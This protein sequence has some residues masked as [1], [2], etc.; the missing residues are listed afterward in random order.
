M[1]PSGPNALAVLLSEPEQLD[2]VP[3]GKA[4]AAFKKIPLQ[5]AA[6]EAKKCWGIVSDNATPA[7]ADGL[8]QALTQ[9]GLR[10]F[11]APAS[12]L[13]GPR[14]PNVVKHINIEDQGLAVEAQP[15][16][17]RV[18]PWTY[19]S[20]IAVSL[21][22]QTVV[23]T[24][25]VEEGPSAAEKLAKTGI[26]LMTGIPLPIARK[27]TVEKK[28]QDSELFFFLDLFLKQSGF[29]IRLDAQNLDYHFL[30]EK[31]ELNVQG[32]FRLLVKEILNRA[33]NALQNRGVRVLAGGQPLTSMGYDTLPDLEKE[34]RW[35]LALATHQTKE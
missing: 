28:V 34:C 23:K 20:V 10:S 30:K 15:G 1:S 7:E 11:S 21:F 19:V 17:F 24:M 9:E 3:L 33:P 5:D 13:A 31:M 4:I 32:N 8:V 27:K 16:Q 12:L 14:T 2:W 35:L 18:V 6:L 22:K 26:T 29:R 25:K